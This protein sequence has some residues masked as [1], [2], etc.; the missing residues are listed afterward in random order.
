MRDVLIRGIPEDTHAWLKTAAEDN[1][2]SMTAEVLEILH[3]ARQR[4]EAARGRLARV[5]AWRKKYL[6]DDGCELDELVSIVRQG[7]THGH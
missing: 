4:A 7:R 5:E 2:R 3:N 6:P 1:N